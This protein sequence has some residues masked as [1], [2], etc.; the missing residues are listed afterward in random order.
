M[1]I[2]IG[3][4]QLLNVTD[5]FGTDIL[6]R[7]VGHPV[8]DDAHNPGGNR[9][10]DNHDENPGEVIPHPVKINGMGA[11]YFINGI[12][13]KDRYIELQHDGDCSQN[14]T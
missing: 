12:S 10:D 3:E 14:N 9:G 8:I 4:R 13:E 1:L 5:G 11:D 7:A 2:Q 6:Y